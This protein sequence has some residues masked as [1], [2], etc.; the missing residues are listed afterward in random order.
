MKLK[1]LSVLILATIALSLLIPAATAAQPENK[2]P[3]TKKSKLDIGGLLM[4]DADRYGEFYSNEADDSTLRSE[5]RRARITLRRQLQDN[6]R[7]KLQLSFND[8]DNE[9]E[10]DDAYLKYNELPWANLTIGKMKEPFGLEKLTSSSAISAIE[11]SMVSTAFAPSRNYGLRLSDAK[12]GYTWAVGIFKEKDD[13]FEEQAPSALSARVTYA[14]LR[15]DRQT[16]HLGGSISLRDWNKNEF[17]IKEKGE[18]NS[19]DNIILSAE[20]DA[21]TVQLTGIEALWQYHSLTL[22]S[23]YMV[24]EVEQPDGLDWHYDG[25]Y[26]QASYFLTGEYLTYKKGRFK[27]VKPNSESG[28]WELLARYSQLDLR[29][30][31]IGAK[32]AVH[33]VGANYYFSSKTV[34]KIN[35][36]SPEIEGH[37]VHSEDSGHALSLRIQSRF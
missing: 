5:L 20:L 21:D 24:T 10:V 27:K 30:N 17:R 31:D 14:P 19:A 15:T 23:E 2:E 8:E 4:I 3:K 11:R 32:A 13:D 12:P 26:L 35:Y 33:T 6:W 29:D 7:I 22:Q 16:I 28:A 37:T 9:V 1:N 36:L 18:V 25:Y 34:V